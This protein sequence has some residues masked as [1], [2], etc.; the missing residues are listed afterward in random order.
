MQYLELKIWKPLGE[1][2]LEKEKLL[3]QVNFFRQN[4][5]MNLQE[6]SHL[7]VIRTYEIPIFLNYK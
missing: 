2:F 7:L 4:I 6:I 5:A 3:R 1:Y